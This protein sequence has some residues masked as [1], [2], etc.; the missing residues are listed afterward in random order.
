MMFGGLPRTDPCLTNYLFGIYD[1][2]Y[3]EK[4]ELYTLNFYKKAKLKQNM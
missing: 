3:D 2:A 1:G 4:T